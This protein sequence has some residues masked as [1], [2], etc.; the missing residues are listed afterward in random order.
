MNEENKL[1]MGHILMMPFPDTELPVM[2]VGLPNGAL[3]T[4][5]LEL[6][7]NKGDG[8]TYTD[9]KWTHFNSEIAALYKK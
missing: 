2:G 4:G 1:N 9:Q 5:K 3:Y 7:E 6:E 8:L